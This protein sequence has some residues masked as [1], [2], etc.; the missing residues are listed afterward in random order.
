MIADPE[1]PEAVNSLPPHF[2][3]PVELQVNVVA[4]PAATDVGLAVKLAVG[5]V[6]GGVDEPDPPDEVTAPPE[7][8]DLLVCVE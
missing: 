4:L 8:K 3:A 6:A 2:V 7:H 1:I 5:G